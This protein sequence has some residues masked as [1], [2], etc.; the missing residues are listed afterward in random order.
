MSNDQD[1]GKVVA[2]YGINNLGKTTQR[3]LLVGRI[4]KETGE[5]PFSMKYP[6]YGLQAIR[7]RNKCISPGRKPLESL[8]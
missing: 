6:L 3:D 4:F 7:S 1:H 5:K 2:L 8:S